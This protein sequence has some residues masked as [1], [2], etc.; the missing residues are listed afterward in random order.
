MNR[1]RCIGRG[2][3]RPDIRVVG[4]GRE[5]DTRKKIRIYNGGITGTMGNR[6]RTRRTESQ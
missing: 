6:L 4:K 3:V 5:N 1:V 2:V